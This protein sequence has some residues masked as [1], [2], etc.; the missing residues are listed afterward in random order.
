MIHKILLVLLA[1][2]VAAFGQSW[3]DLKKV[4]NV[5][6]SHTIA[7]DGAIIGVAGGVS[8]EVGVFFSKAGSPSYSHASVRLDKGELGDVGVVEPLIFRVISIVDKLNA[9]CSVKSDGLD[10]ANGM[11][12]WVSNI[13]TLDLVDD[14]SIIILGPVTL[15]EPREYRTAKGSNAKV[16][17][18]ELFDKD[19]GLKWEIDRSKRVAEREKDI[20]K[21]LE[22]QRDIELAKQFREF[23]SADGKFSVKARFLEFKNSL[24]SLEKQD[25]KIVNVK[26]SVLSKDDVRWI[27]EK[28]KEFK[29][30][31]DQQKIDD[32]LKK[33]GISPG[34]DEWLQSGGSVSK[35]DNDSHDRGGY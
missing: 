12:V 30:A 18:I 10:S 13:P 22:E 25:G 14:Q 15:V 4:S 8:R 33:M 16:R 31:K 17:S 29:A 2:P 3:G 35:Q 21:K 20:A 26:M 32:K 23:K 9:I 5:P 28:L 27:Q 7:R 11:T 19:P 1:F 6:Y 24:V 34:S